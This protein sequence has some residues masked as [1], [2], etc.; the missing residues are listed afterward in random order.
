[1]LS[2]VIVRAA[3]DPELQQVAEEKGANGVNRVGPVVRATSCR[4][5]VVTRFQAIT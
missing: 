4:C 2:D 1:M 3:Q 5:A